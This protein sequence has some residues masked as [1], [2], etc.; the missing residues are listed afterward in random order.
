MPVRFRV[1]SPVVAFAA[2]VAVVLSGCA[3]ETAPEN[4]PTPS[5]PA[6]EATVPGET[7][8]ALVLPTC[9]ELLTADDIVTIL[10]DGY[11]EFSPGEDFEST[12]VVPDERVIGVLEDAVK[13]QRCGWGVPH[14][15]DASVYV[16]AEVESAAAA[17]LRSHLQSEADFTTTDVDGAPVTTWEEQTGFGHVYAVVSLDTLLIAAIDYNDDTLRHLLTALRKVNPSLPAGSTATPSVSPSATPGASPTPTTPATPR[18]DPGDRAVLPECDDLLPLSTVHALFGDAAERLDAGG[19][20][21]DHMPGPLAAETVRAAKQSKVCTWGIPFS[22]G[23]FGV[24]AAEITATA[25]DRLL[26]S[27]RKAS[28]YTE[29]TLDGELSFTHE[30]ESEFGTIAVVYVFVGDVWIT[31]NGTLSMATAREFAGSAVDAVRSANA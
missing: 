18:P 2:A 28:S 29:R 3:P 31:V 1:L 10:G 12:T 24:V 8:G 30:S 5:S 15:S 17:D 26:R 25:R 13:S 9:G 7:T 4:T 23:G 19:S 21:A 11:E 22:D 16:I 14:T 20:A 27:L 6:P